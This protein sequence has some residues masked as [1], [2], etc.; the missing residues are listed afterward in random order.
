[1]K[2]HAMAL[3]LAG[4]LALAVAARA[5]TVPVWITDS[6]DTLYY[7]EVYFPGTP[8]A[9]TVA[10]QVAEITSR[11]Q[12]EAADLRALSNRARASGWDN[13]AVVYD[14]M[15]S[16]HQNGAQQASSWLAS[17]DFVVPA[18]PQATLVADTAPDA[19]VS[20]MIQMHEE[21][22]TEAAQE[23][24]GEP[25]STVRGLL[26][27]EMATAARHLT[28]L[29]ALDNDI[30]RG[31][32]SLSARLQSMLDTDTVASNREDLIGRAIT[33][34]Q[35]YYH[36]LITETLTAQTPY[37][38]EAPQVVERIVEKPVTVERIV[39][40]PVTV[41]KIV[42]KPVYITQPQ[43]QVAGSRTVVRRRVIHRRPA[44]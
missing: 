6:G 44:K 2:F 43:S 36:S 10:D 22:F 4:T 7:H 17:N 34:D 20:R 14:A 12:Q 25:S 29:R 13:I 42:E 40:K 8:D 9:Q 33:E 38:P 15:A 19:S 3:C 26:L 35:E 28:L 18:F 32:K 21:M 31:R 24:R 23:R 27:M 39:E 37:T 30:S 1:M 5:D 11:E 16:D 41:E